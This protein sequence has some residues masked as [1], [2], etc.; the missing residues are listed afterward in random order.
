MYNTKPKYEHS[1]IKAFWEKDL[2]IVKQ[3]CMNA[4]ASIHQGDSTTTP[5]TLV[6]EAGQLLPFFYP[7]GTEYSCGDKNCIKCFPDITP[8]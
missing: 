4:I 5:E 3:V 8:F 6:K 7:K 1:E 2:L